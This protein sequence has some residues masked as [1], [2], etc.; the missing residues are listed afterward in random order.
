GGGGDVSVAAGGGRGSGLRGVGGVAWGGERRCGCRGGG[1]VFRR[2]CAVHRDVAVCR[3]QG[4]G[5]QPR[6]GDVLR[7]GDRA[8]VGVGCGRGVVGR[9]RSRV[10]LTAAGREAGRAATGRGRRVVQIGA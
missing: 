2:G 1:G 3:C 6:G 9:H 4:R 7:H 5:V 10:V 8:A